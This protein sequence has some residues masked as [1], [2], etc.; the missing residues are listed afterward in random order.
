MSNDSPA[1]M[2]FDFS[3]QTGCRRCYLTE[4]ER[5]SE[6]KRLESLGYTVVPYTI[7]NYPIIKHDQ[8]IHRYSTLLELDHIQYF[9][10][11]CLTFSKRL[12]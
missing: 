3:D 9:S 10:G 8:G 5:N 2:Y 4:S 11:W 1:Y 7:D 12:C 6:V